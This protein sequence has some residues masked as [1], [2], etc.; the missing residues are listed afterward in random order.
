MGKILRKITVLRVFC[1]LLLILMLLIQVESIE[2]ANK[3]DWE[4]LTIWFIASLTLLLADYLLLK[5]INSKLELC[6]WESLIAAGV[7]AIYFSAA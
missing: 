1:F 5:K 6:I 2:T 3:L 4:V 7:L